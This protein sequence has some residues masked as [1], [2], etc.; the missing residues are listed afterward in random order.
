MR[1]GETELQNYLGAAVHACHS[2]SVN[3]CDVKTKCAKR[4]LSQELT[5]ATELQACF[6][7]VIAWPE[8]TGNCLISE[9]YGTS[10]QGQTTV[11]LNTGYEKYNP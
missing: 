11:D 5:G 1:R 7:L 6:H 3:K 9:Q 8:L 2:C 10:T 4:F